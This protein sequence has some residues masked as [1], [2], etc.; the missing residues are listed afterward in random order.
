M[1][2]NIF[3]GAFSGL[4]IYYLFLFIHF[5]LE[6]IAEV[7]AFRSS[8]SKN[9]LYNL[10]TDIGGLTLLLIPLLYSLAMF[11][12]LLSYTKQMQ[13]KQLTY[14][15]LL[16]FHCLLLFAFNKQWLSTDWLPIDN[17]FLCLVLPILLLLIMVSLGLYQLYEMIAK[18]RADKSN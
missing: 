16:L 5:V 1:K 9:G 14:V 12:L 4:V 10:L 8:S 11:I 18:K 6:L 2:K 3:F 15:F 13:Q 7:Q 17:T